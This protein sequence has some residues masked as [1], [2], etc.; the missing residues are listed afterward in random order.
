[1]IYPIPSVRSREFHE[2]HGAGRRE[3]YC[4]CIRMSSDAS[5]QRCLIGPAAEAKIVFA[6]VATNA[7]YYEEAARLATNAKAILNAGSFHCMAVAVSDAVIKTQT[8]QLLEPLL[9]PGRSDW[10]PPAEWCT[11]RKLSGW[12]HTSILKL[13]LMQLVLSAGLGIFVV[14]VDWRF[15]ADPLPSL[16]GC[17]F[18]LIGTRDNHFVNIG[19]ML[20]RS[21]PATIAIARRA[22]NRS[23]AA[24]DQA[25]VNEEL[26]GE[27]AAPDRLS[28]CVANDFF[29]AFMARK[30]GVNEAKK[31]QQPLCADPSSSRLAGL[32]SQP[33]GS[34]PVLGPPR[35]GPGAPPPP[36]M[37][38]GR[39]W[40][41]SRFN[42]ISST[43]HHRCPG[44]Y[45]HCSR[46][47]C[48][49][50][51]A[52]LSARTGDRGQGI[53]RR[54]DDGG[55]GGALGGSGTCSLRD[56]D[57][58]PLQPRKRAHL[59]SQK[60]P[61][62]LS[63]EMPSSMDA[64]VGLSHAVHLR[65][66]D[67]LPARS[68]DSSGGG[69]G[70]AHRRDDVLE[71]C[72][73]S[74]GC[75]ER[76]PKACKAQRHTK[77]RRIGRDGKRGG[78][79]GSAGSYALGALAAHH[80]ACAPMSARAL[81]MCL[82]V[83]ES[84][85]GTAAQRVAQDMGCRLPYNRPGVPDYLQLRDRRPLAASIRL[86]PRTACP[87]NA[88][89]R[90]LLIWR[91]SFPFNYMEFVRRILGE[92][93][94]LLAMRG[95]RPI[96]YAPLD[97]NLSL[98]SYFYSLLGTPLQGSVHGNLNS[99]ALSAARPGGSRGM[100]QDGSGGDD[101]AAGTA[102]AFTSATLCCIKK[103]TKINASA[104]IAFLERVIDDH[105]TG[106]AGS[107]S[108]SSQHDVLIVTRAPHPWASPG[109]AR[110]IVGLR[111]L[112]AACQKSGRTCATI[113]FG[114][115]PFAEAV[116]RVRAAR[117]LIGV[118]GA[119]L[120]NAVFLKPASVA[121][122]L[123][124]KAFAASAH[125]FGAAKFG[126]LPALGVRHVRLSVAESDPRCVERARGLAEKL[127]DCDVMVEWRAVDQAL[128][129]MASGLATR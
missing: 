100:A 29:T 81:P 97:G 56:Q 53:S 63:S 104:A 8:N 123:T 86:P 34:L 62:L 108:S 112:L 52:G 47:R 84:H 89:R 60:V 64:G 119:G 109:S 79:G 101:H 39:G 73:W 45:N 54:G 126:F 95:Q 46:A 93:Q 24:W 25:L 121:V 17:N 51:Q 99:V 69:S 42:E 107:A 22:A 72:T 11:R 116:R 27:L 18:D 70:S 12:R 36:P 91:Q 20:V 71:E 113:D 38:A 35:V 13:G 26:S 114:A 118:H 127:R 44:C 10:R 87:A 83:G 55:V 85:A 43:Y 19:L 7:F 115:L 32:G 117:A 14:D 105:L 16:L 125:S 6:S 77:V 128:G 57:G 92:A 9:L 3:N 65:S 23:V 122:E 90:P 33:L 28:C 75:C 48:A 120:A 37:W 110:R 82:P 106:T 78:G 129:G 1:M 61:T 94:T 96:V 31:R 68:M 67:A 80:G 21:T 102:L 15:R 98:P 59:T 49:F 50:E 58:R 2:F 88:T 30:R 76:H 111:A 66:V 41:G 40:D 4:T 124:P 5:W 74:N 103:P